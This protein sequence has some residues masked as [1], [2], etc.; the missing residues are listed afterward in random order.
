MYTTSNTPTTSNNT[1]R[2]DNTISVPI[3]EIVP[4]AYDGSEWFIYFTNKYQNVTTDDYVVNTETTKKVW[5][6]NV[7][8]DVNITYLVWELVTSES[9][10]IK[11]TNLS[12]V[13]IGKVNYTLN[14]FVND[15]DLDNFMETYSSLYPFSMWIYTTHADKIIS[16]G[17][18]PIINADMYNNTDIFP[19]KIECINNLIKYPYNTGNVVL[20]YAN[21]IRNTLPEVMKL[22][23]FSVITQEYILNSSGFKMP[24]E[25]LLNNRNAPPWKTF[26]M[27]WGCLGGWISKTQIIRP[28]NNDSKIPIIIEFISQYKWSKH[29][30][31][32]TD[33]FI[34]NILDISSDYIDRRNIPF[35]Y[36]N[37][38]YP[39][40]TTDSTEPMALYYNKTSEFVKDCPPSNDVLVNEINDY[41]QRKERNIDLW[42]ADVDL[43]T[44]DMP[45]KTQRKKYKRRV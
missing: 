39:H 9:N 26:N 44:E 40:I 10:T 20:T 1:G 36:N 42:T 22:Q 32:V 14:S 17:T 6:N 3:S 23:L 25:L 11:Y 28:L 5:W 7:I 35:T 19:N 27:V 16:V 24:K 21:Y 33:R 30:R 8:S 12:I 18:C 4:E 43:L 37:V 38:K 2:G 15:T 45:K 29:T 41:Y 31:E 34:K 13:N